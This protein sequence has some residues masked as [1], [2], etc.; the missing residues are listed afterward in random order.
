[1]VGKRNGTIIS[2]KKSIWII[3][4]YAFLLF[5][6]AT[7]IRVNYRPHFLDQRIPNAQTYAKNICV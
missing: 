7:R 2:G 3:F 6:K 4:E 1:M 5:A